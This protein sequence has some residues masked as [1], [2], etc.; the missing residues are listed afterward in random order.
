MAKEQKLLKRI[1]ELEVENMQMRIVLQEAMYAL[2]SPTGHEEL[3]MEIGEA[4]DGK[5]K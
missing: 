3:I 2:E 1:K 5:Y 4:L